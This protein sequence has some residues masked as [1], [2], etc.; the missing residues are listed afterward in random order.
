MNYR[1]ERTRPK[2]FWRMDHVPKW[3]KGKPPAYTPAEVF[4]AKSAETRR[5]A[6]G[7]ESAD[8]CGRARQGKG[9]VSLAQK[10]WPR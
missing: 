5:Q 3:P 2:L 10:L 7:G 1:H 6:L 9:G 4:E 8:S